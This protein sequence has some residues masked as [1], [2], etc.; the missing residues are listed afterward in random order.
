MTQTPEEFKSP[1]KTSRQGQDR[2]L[3]ISKGNHPEGGQ[4]QS[5]DPLADACRHD[6]DTAI[7]TPVPTID[8][9]DED[10]DMMGFMSLNIDENLR[11][12]ALRKFF[13]LPKF[14]RRDGLDDYDEDFQSFQNLG[15]ILTSDMRYHLERLSEEKTGSCLKR[16][17]TANRQPETIE[18][19]AGT[20]GSESGHISRHKIEKPIPGIK[21]VGDLFHQPA[22]CAHGAGGLAGCTRC[23]DAC[24]AGAISSA[25]TTIQIDPEIC[26]QKGLC[27][28]VCPTDALR[29]SSPD[30]AELPDSIRSMLSASL[31][32][33]P[34]VIFH[35]G[36]CAPALLQT[37]PGEA[38]SFSVDSIESIGMDTC[39]ATLALGASHVVVLAGDNVTPAV[40]KILQAQMSHAKKILEGMGLER[41]RVQLVRVDG[42]NQE[43]HL[44]DLINLAPVRPTQPAQFAPDNTKRSLILQSVDYLY[45]QA[46]GTRPVAALSEGA[47][48]GEI[49]I[50]PNTCT[51]CMACVAVC[52]AKVLYDG[53]EIPQ[54]RFLEAHCVQCGLCRRA[55][56]ENAIHLSPRMI[57]DSKARSFPRI[58]IQAETF[59]CV[60]CG[61]PFATK[62]IVDKM[63]QK[64]S[65]HWMYQD[66][67]AKQRLLM[68]RECRA[69][70]FFEA[71]GGR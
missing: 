25:G 39:L 58:L 49:L 57:F 7:P 12:S 38:L 1:S 59:C 6:S 46:P 33:N 69:R 21:K 60:A 9:L 56:P 30:S 18:E 16:D 20:A 67:A 32:E 54:I 52:P 71:G 3:K 24:P 40:F 35:D 45:G 43:A 51:L 53:G 36:G 11:K 48:F 28:T 26:R 44:T 62:A 23:L 55:C 68:C 15:N 27:A 19:S 50:D 22:L 31:D 34:A 14:N 2:Q 47:P 13:H 70:D 65:G 64:L 29:P 4:Y 41:E 63:V 8:N 17:P 5:D 66:D 10:S 61:R 42:R 37:L